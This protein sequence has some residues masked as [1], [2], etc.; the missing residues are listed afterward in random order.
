MLADGPASLRFA[1]IA[2]G[3]A[4]VYLFIAGNNWSIRPGDLDFGI[5][6]MAGEAVAGGRDPYEVWVQTTDIKAYFIYPPLP[7]VFF[8]A[9]TPLGLVAASYAWF[10]A[11]LALLAWAVRMAFRAIED[12]WGVRFSSSTMA[13]AL[14]V[15]SL[16]S[17]DLLKRELWH[18]QTDIVLVAAIVIALRE[19][20]RRPWLAGLAIGIAANVKFHAVVFVPLMLVRARWAAAGWSVLATAALAF[21][22]AVVLGWELNLKG[23]GVALGGIGQF[24]G[25]GEEGWRVPALDWRFSLSIP[26]ALSKAG[27]GAGQVLA[28]TGVIGLA[29]AGAAWGLYASRGRRLFARPP[30][31]P[32]DRALMLVEWCGL[33]V[34]LL[35][36]GPQTTKRHMVL[37]LP[38]FALVAGLLV[39]FRR[40]AR[41]DRVWLLAAMLVYT[42]G[43]FLPPRS[44]VFEAAAE[45]W[46]SV[47]G[48]SWCLLVLYFA[49]MAVVVRAFPAARGERSP[50][51][52]AAVPRATP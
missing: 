17:A 34:A 2:V 5:F 39:M 41:G 43:A 47:A 24:I 3:A 8:A 29:C 45:A 13:G 19:L 49:A 48:R 14:A 9:L 6:F 20:D 16:L 4:V 11:N 26:S 1:W 22:P 40:I 32:S 15:L 25:L 33:I 36:L 31:D 51:A 44:G 42:L 28:I 50:G 30:G 12:A 7:A 35:A 21:A 23:W 27:L 46:R 10:A 18:G 38:F 37:A 52:G